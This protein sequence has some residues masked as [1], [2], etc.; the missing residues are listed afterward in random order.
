MV[1]L[2]SKAVEEKGASARRTGTKELEAKAAA[3][4]APATT[5]AGEVERGEPAAINAGE[6][7]RGEEVSVAAWRSLF[8]NWVTVWAISNWV[9]FLAGGSEET[10][11]GEAER[12]L[13][14]F[15]GICG[16]KKRKGRRKEK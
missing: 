12:L 7:V 16:K 4:M 8:S 14:F 11:L 6:V 15:A 10:E 3:T 13:P 5:N 2:A 9:V 1:P